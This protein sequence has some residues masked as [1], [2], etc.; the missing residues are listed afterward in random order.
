ELHGLPRPQPRLELLPLNLA[1]EQLEHDVAQCAPSSSRVGP[2]LAVEVL[3]HVL[4]L[5]VRHGMTLAS[6]EHAF[7]ARACTAAVIP[8]LACSGCSTTGSPTAT[9]TKP[10]GPG[11]SSAAPT[12]ARW[13]ARAT[14]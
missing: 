6:Y 7:N 8:S 11:S 13:R 9:C 3:G 14:S 1:G 10:T 5:K 4:D 2:Q 12:R